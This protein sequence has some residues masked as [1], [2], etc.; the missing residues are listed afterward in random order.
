MALDNY[1]AERRNYKPPNIVA[2]MTDSLSLPTQ[3]SPP[4]PV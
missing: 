1:S 2:V 3:S 4:Q